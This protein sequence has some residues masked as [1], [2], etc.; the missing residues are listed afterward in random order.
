MMQPLMIPNGHPNR[1]SLRMMDT[2]A[3]EQND[4]GRMARKV[5]DE[6]VET[7]VLP[8]SVQEIKLKSTDS[9]SS[10]IK[11]IHIQKG[12]LVFGLSVNIVANV[13]VM[14]T[15]VTPGS[16]CDRDGRLSGGDVIVSVNGRSLVPPLAAPWVVGDVLRSVDRNTADV[17]VQYIPSDLSEEST[18]SPL[19]NLLSSF[20][21]DEDED[22]FFSMSETSPLPLS[23][24]TTLVS[25]TPQ[26]PLKLVEPAVIEPVEKIAPKEPPVERIATKEPSVERI[27]PILP[28]VQSK[29]SP[30]ILSAKPV[31]APK[32]KLAAAPLPISPTKSLD[33]SSIVSRVKPTVPFKP[34]RSS[35]SPKDAFPPKAKPSTT[36]V[37]GTDPVAGRQWGPERKV[38]LIRDP[39]KGLGISIV[40]GRMDSVRGGIFIKNVMPDSP[41]GWNGTLKRGDRI[42][43]VSGLDLRNADHAKAVDVIKNASSPVTFIIQSLVQLP[44]KAGVETSTVIIPPSTSS[45]EEIVVSKLPES[46]V[47]SPSTMQPLISELQPIIPVPMHSDNSPK[48]PT[49]EM[50]DEVVAVISNDP[51]TENRPEVSSFKVSTTEEELEDKIVELIPLAEGK[52]WS[53]KG[54]QVDIKSAANMKLLPFEKDSDP[55][56]EDEYGYT[57]SKFFNGKFRCICCFQVFRR[58]RFSDVT[59][60]RK[61]DHRVRP[62]RASTSD[63]VD[64]KC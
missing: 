6:P 48:S 4:A 56:P 10:H 20:K 21:S 29:I 2:D 53:K 51:S 43:E 27:A 33:V 46:K 58:K 26:S 64:Y 3:E 16:A 9:Q 17:V 55:E 41:A 50:T 44:R 34:M 23:Q 18:S 38:E 40:S 7:V 47:L 57:M 35:L 28:T 32:P 30:I 37:D 11:T 62:F 45:S 22:E 15:S 54:K 36:P 31:I 5:K 63:I 14:V 1:F 25:E 60:K 59:T 8:S 13:G 49:T 39:V 24:S 42:L 19:P 12:E 61:L 52:V